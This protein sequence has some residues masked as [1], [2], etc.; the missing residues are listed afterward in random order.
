MTKFTKLIL[1]ALFANLSLSLSA[2][3]TTWVQTLDFNMI[4]ERSGT[5]EFP[6]KGS[7]SYE[8]VL[9]YYTLKCDPKTT[10]DGYDCGE[11][12][13]LTYTYVWDSTGNLDST[14]LQQANYTI[15][16]NTPDSFKYTTKPVY[17]YTTTQYQY[18]NITAT[19]TSKV[20]TIYNSGLGTT[21]RPL[22]T[23]SSDGR[24]YF[25]WRIDEL[26]NAGLTIGAIN[27]IKLNIAN[28]GSE[29][30]NLT[31]RLKNTYLDSLTNA[32]LETTGYT[33]C[34]FR[35]TKFSGTGWQDINFTNDFFWDGVSNI[36]VEFCYNNKAEAVSNDVYFDATTFQSGMTYTSDNPTYLNFDGANDYITT[37]DATSLGMIDNSFT[38]ETW[39]YV[40]KYENG[41]EGIVGN[42][43]W[44][45]TSKG[46]H[47]ALR[48]EKPYMGFFGNDMG[49]N[50]T[51]A[52]QKWYHI[53]YVYD[54]AAGR[55]SIYVNGK[56]DKTETGHNPFTGDSKIF[57]GRLRN[58]NFFNGS[59]DEMKIW[60][61]A[62]SAGTI[63]EWMNKPLDNNHP[64]YANLTAYYPFNDG[65]GGVAKDASVNGYDGKLSGIPNWVEE[66]GCLVGQRYLKGTNER[67]GIAFDQ[68][69][70]TFT[71]ESETVVDS[72]L[73]EQTEVIVFGNPNDPGN[74]TDTIYV[75]E[76]DRYIY[77]LD[78]GGGVSDSV[79]INKEN[80]FVKEIRNYFSEPF[81]VIN[82]IEIGRYITPYGIGL[83]LGPDGFTWIFDVT[84][85]TPILH[86]Y[87]RLAAGNTQELIDLKFAMVKGT[88]ARNVISVENL[89]SGSR[90][91]KDIADNTQF[92]PKKIGLDQDG[93]NFRIKTRTS[94]HGFGS[95]ENCAEFCAK[96]HFIT[97]DGEEKFRWLVWKECSTNP[98]YPQGGTWIYDRSGWCPGAIVDTYDHELQ[99]VNGGDSITVDYG[100]EA[101]Q[102]NGEG[103]YVVETQL[104]TYGAPNFTNDAGVMHILAPNNHELYGRMNPICG[105]PIIVIQNTGSE[106]LTS[107]EIEY[108][109][110]GGALNKYTWTGEL[111]FLDSAVVSMPWAN[112]GNFTP[113][114][115]GQDIFEVTVKNPNGKQDE[116]AT[117]NVMKSYIDMPAVFPRNI[118]VVF[119]PNNA[120]DETSWKIIN[121]D[122][123]GEII[124]Q[125]PS[126][127]QTGQTYR[128]KVE[129]KGFCYKFIVEDK[130]QDGLSF[131]AN[132]D[133]TGFI[134]LRVDGGGLL[135]LF[136]ANFGSSVEMS[137][138]AVHSL[139]VDEQDNT[140]YVKAYPNP[141]TGLVLLDVAL[142]EQSEA[143][144][145]VTNS[146][147]QVVYTQTSSL[148]KE[149]VEVELP[150]VNGTY[151]IKVI[152]PNK[153]Y[154]QK[155]VV[156]Q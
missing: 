98:V 148:F 88:P 28:L 82:R 94:G 96:E 134:Q 105:N 137:F 115:N 49:G 154:I 36:I 33:D 69:D 63:A 97:I 120:A 44:G 138:T 34:Y 56:L 52:T 41:D 59:L 100:V 127:V 27:G 13:Y 109:I 16:G 54:K 80:R 22:S 151:F 91:Y 62:L 45:T 108:R 19:N 117:N 101:Y 29:V 140:S 47:L 155:V 114:G 122:G 31:I 93:K 123:S 118:E 32:N 147:G 156:M 126:T 66:N 129:L 124:A 20:S 5:F 15:N 130:D 18:K 99:G 21:D 1:L 75:W 24:S 71:I 37:T 60:N 110:Q 131:F 9:M 48:S 17:K 143:T 125:S 90:K 55:Q 102:F 50:T 133:G 92:T 73:E 57:I 7:E 78:A 106:K 25:L 144:I 61:K 128:D 84:D 95:G 87:V 6:K 46:L 145:Q 103:N 150:Q 112:W 39:V 40:D 85:Y 86:D 89:Y 67:P 10:R 70:Y 141:T 43:L 116:Y 64:D 111:E 79:F 53:A 58:G 83:D 35:N 149:L 132:N 38:V 136:N 81:E 77:K 104:I 8:K 72:T 135:K 2:Q 30:H 14:S 12:D 142:T 4:T 76:A 146:L 121:A 51:I 3:D 74:A 11:W 113:K 107:L 26:N 153:T 139:S 65:V 68:S 23:A 42:E 152:T 119:R